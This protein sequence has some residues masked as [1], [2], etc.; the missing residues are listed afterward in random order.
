MGS[1]SVK[2]GVKKQLYLFYLFET[3]ILTYELLLRII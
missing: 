2:I 3:M 1:A